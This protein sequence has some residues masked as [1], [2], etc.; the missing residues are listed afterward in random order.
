MTT[1][2]G[3]AAARG[4]E[5]TKKPNDYITARECVS[6]VAECVTHALRLRDAEAHANRW[7]RR[8]FPTVFRRRKAVLHV[9]R[10]RSQRD[11]SRR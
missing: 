9:E 5:Y 10:L 4:K 2:P 7:Y 11:A 1:T 6:I 3:Q 8:I